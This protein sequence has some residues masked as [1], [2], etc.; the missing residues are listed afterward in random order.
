M[1]KGR[2]VTLTSLL[3][4]LLGALSACEDRSQVSPEVRQAQQRAEQQ[5]PPRPTTQQ[6]LTGPRKR[7]ALSPIPFSVGVPMSWKIGTPKDGTVT[8]LEGPTPSGDAQIQI[9][10]HPPLTKD[11]LDIILHG[12][13]KE[14]TEE[15]KK[16]QIDVRQLSPNITVLERRQIG[17]PGPLLV[18]P[19]RQEKEITATNYKWTITMFVPR[20]DKQF[21]QDELNFVALTREQY[22][23]DKELLDGIV[24][25]LQF[26]PSAIPALPAASQPAAAPA[27]P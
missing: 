24:K 5:G 21:D 23:Q 13:K 17:M 9:N 25:S 18:G 7:L 4:L 3:L 12:A 2:C 8:I 10:L 14:A 11:K 27:V 20:E 16:V 6:L 19:P 22:D 15:P 1:D 26:D